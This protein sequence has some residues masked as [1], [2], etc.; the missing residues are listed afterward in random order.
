MNFYFLFLH[1]EQSGFTMFLQDYLISYLNL[2]PEI[3][4]SYLI[5]LKSTNNRDFQKFVKVGLCFQIF[6]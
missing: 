5:A 3:S 4:Q 6:M 1:F 2:S